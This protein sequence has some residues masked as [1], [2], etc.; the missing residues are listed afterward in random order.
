MEKTLQMLM[1]ADF[2][3]EDN[4]LIRAITTDSRAVAPGSLFL[5]LPGLSHDARAFIPQALANG[6]SAIAYDTRD[7]FQVSAQGIP[8][9][10][11][12]DLQSKCG[13]IAARFYDTPSQAMPVIAVTGTNGKTSCC[14]FIAQ[15][16]AAL[17][18][19][20][21]VVGTLGNGI[22]PEL[23]KGA[24]TTP[25]ALQLQLVFAHL[26]KHAVDIVAMEASSHAIAQHRIAGVNM[27]VGVFTQLSRDHLDYHGSM[28]A[29]AQAKKQLFSQPGMQYG[30][31]NLDDPIG[32]EIVEE[33][34]SRLALIGYTL[35][36]NPSPY[37]FP[38]IALQHYDVVPDGFHIEMT[39]EDETAQCI[40]PLMGR[41]NIA[42]LFA[43]IG[44][45]LCLGFSLQ[46]IVSH[47]QTLETATGRM[48]SFGGGKKPIIVVDF[49]HT[50][51]ALQNAL[52]ALREHCH[53]KLWCVFGCGGDRDPGKRE[54]MGAV[55]ATWSDHIVIT[56]DNPRSESP[57][58]IAHAILSGVPDEVETTIELN[59]EAAIGYAVQS[60]K[61]EDIVLV[62]GK[63]HETE[64][65][66]NDT[67]RPF[68]DIEH[69]QNQLKQRLDG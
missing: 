8:V 4:P 44:S 65:I 51:D 39:F 24:F 41:Y 38:V 54:Q 67:I 7:Q 25:D 17:Q 50:P 49:A 62:A 10:P 55:A 42:N 53:G 34:Q 16:M 56:N 36:S 2:Q 18:K 1:G 68:S 12:D 19:R 47:V 15:L 13:W 20:C 66:I 46:A 52:C 29:Y 21:G 22:W 9:L 63:G 11:V 5:A 59:R 33:T 43:V 32:K 60:A 23:E 30:V 31:V 45:L 58:S 6:A 48:Q 64:Q 37:A 61:K 28:Q 57:E 35:Q 14:L 3:G 26:K 40:L 27:N 69:V